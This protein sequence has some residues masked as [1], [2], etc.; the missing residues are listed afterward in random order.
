MRFELV[1]LRKTL[2]PTPEEMKTRKE[3]VRNTKGLFQ[4]EM[5]NRLDITRQHYSNLENGLT[6]PSFELMVKFGEVFKGEYE[7]MWE[8]W[9]NEQ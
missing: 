5:A 2:E 4:E 8:L 1:K 6:N 9:K 7:D 3:S